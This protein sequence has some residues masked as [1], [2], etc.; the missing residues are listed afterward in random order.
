[1]QVKRFNNLQNAN[2]ISSINT[3]KNSSSKY[4]QLP[5]LF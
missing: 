1:M 5:Y 3:I 4:Y 2:N